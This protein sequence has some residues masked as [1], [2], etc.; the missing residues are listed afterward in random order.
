M[1]GEVRMVAI[2]RQEAA[3]LREHAANLEGQRIRF[4]G[5]ARPPGP[6]EALVTALIERYEQAE[7]AG[8]RGG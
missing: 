8:R 2:S 3:T 7:E 6:G 1:S 4:G 5:G